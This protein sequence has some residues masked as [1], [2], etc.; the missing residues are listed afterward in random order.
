MISTSQVRLRIQGHRN[1]LGGWGVRGGGRH[2]MKCS[3]FWVD[4]HQ[5]SC[6]YL[7]CNQKM[8]SFLKKK[9]KG[10][11][12]GGGRK[13]TGTKIIY[14][15]TLTRMTRSRDDALALEMGEL[16]RTL[17]WYSLVTPILLV[18]TSK[19]FSNPGGLARNRKSMD[20]GKKVKM[21]CILQEY[22]VRTASKYNPMHL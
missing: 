14:S 22:A 19:L 11:G 13:D 7:L 2:V 9:K 1:I 12:G 10:V 20:V 17:H 3:K 8:P 5:Y 18:V 6:R 21:P 15:C 4:G 16:T